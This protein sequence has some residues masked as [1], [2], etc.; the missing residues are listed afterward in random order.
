MYA[1][2]LTAFITFPLTDFPDIDE[3]AVPPYITAFFTSK[4]VKLGLFAHTSA[5][6]PAAYG[7]AMDVPFSI[8]YGLA[9]AQMP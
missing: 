5:A 7:V 2:A 1:K 9:A 3:T 6:S 8:A 4:Y